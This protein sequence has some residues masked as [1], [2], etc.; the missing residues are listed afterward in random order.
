MFNLSDAYTKECLAIRV[1][2]KITANHVIETLDD[3]PRQ[4]GTPRIMRSANS[5]EF[6]A[7]LSRQ[8]LKDLGV[9]T[10]FIEPGSSWEN[11]YLESLNRK[12]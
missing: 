2:K 3:L 9:Q 10:A 4:I 8:W 7:E 6:V 11:R 12:Y 1:G 5:P